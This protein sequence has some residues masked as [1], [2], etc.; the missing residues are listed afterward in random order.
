MLLDEEQ[1]AAREALDALRVR[2]SGG[3]TG[4]G[5]YLWGSVGRGKTM[6]MDEFYDSIPVGKRRIHFH[7]FFADLHARAHELGSMGS[8]LDHVAD[9]IRVLCFDEFHIDDVADAMFMARVLDTIVAKGVTVVVTSNVPPTELL[10]NPL[11]HEQFVPS[12]ELIELTLEVIEL[13]G[14]IDYRTAGQPSAGDY[15]FA[16]GEF[17]VDS[18]IVRPSGEGVELT[19]GT[20]TL[21]CSAIRDGVVWFDFAVLCGGST[22]AADYLELASRFDDWVIFGVPVLEEASE[23]AVR[24]F[25]NVVDV[26][27]DVDARLTVYADACVGEVAGSLR[28]VPGLARLYSRLSLLART[29]TDSVGSGSSINSR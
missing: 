3:E 16:T 9:G 4:G 18:E 12:I 19:I 15:R 24:R 29:E 8:A 26:L 2:I 7:R 6:L 10:P 13:G 11:F 1:L 28:D 25:G 5:I 22:S 27:Y 21:A 17:L 14:S 20:R 23:F